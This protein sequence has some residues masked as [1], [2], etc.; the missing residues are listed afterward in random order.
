MVLCN[1]TSLFVLTFFKSAQTQLRLNSD[2]K[3]SIL[4]ASL[5][6]VTNIPWVSHPSQ[7]TDD[8]VE[9]DWL[10]NNEASSVIYRSG[11]PRDYKSRDI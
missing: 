9:L 8:L 2:L 10:I 11:A 5:K 3:L 1:W 6:S 4:V 7:M